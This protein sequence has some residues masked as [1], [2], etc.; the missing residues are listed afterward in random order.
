MYMQ[1]LDWNEFIGGVLKNHSVSLTVGVF[2]GVHRGHQALIRE[3]CSLSAYPV[4]VTFRK[5]PLKI[6]DPGNFSGNICSLEEKL[7]IFNDLGVKFV[8]LID[9]SKKFSKIKGIDFIN[10]LIKSCKIKHFVL[11]Q[12]FRCGFML[13]TGFED[14]LKTDVPVRV[15]KAVFEGGQAISSSRIRNAICCGNL[16]EAALLLGRTPEI[17]L[18]K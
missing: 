11:G 12:N 2:D 5:N 13:D 18:L 14:L 3:T 8:V 16:K 15:V 4:I 1:I 10:L 17:E 7:E 9:F 6:L